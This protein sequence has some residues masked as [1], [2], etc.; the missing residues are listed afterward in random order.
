MRFLAKQSFVHTE[1]HSVVKQ[2]SESLSHLFS[3]KFK[4]NPWTIYILKKWTTEMQQF[5]KLER[6]HNMLLA[7]VIK[8]LDIYVIALQKPPRWYFD[9][10]LKHSTKA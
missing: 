7:F 6:Q 1:N 9:L 4:N 2:V 3:Y 5:E 8:Q 10:R